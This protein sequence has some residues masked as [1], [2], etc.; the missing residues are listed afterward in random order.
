MPY[1]QVGCKAFSKPV[2]WAVT[3]TSAS[4]IF[5]PLI[6][7]GRLLGQEMDVSHSPC[8]LDSDKSPCGQALVKS[9]S[10]GAYLCEGEQTSLSIFQ[11]VSFSPFCIGNR[12]D[13]YYHLHHLNLL[14]FTE[15]KSVAVLLKLAFQEFLYLKQST[16]VS[17]NQ[18]VTLCINTQ[19]WL[20]WLFLLKISCDALCQ[21][22]P[23]FEAVVCPLTYLFVCFFL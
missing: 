18:L 1:H 14:G 16:L 3:L 2:P 11:S 6:N 5:S 17:D 8:W 23:V 15:G 13:F 10:L 20:Q 12:R 4:G 19:F 22:V 7:T 9:F 21:F